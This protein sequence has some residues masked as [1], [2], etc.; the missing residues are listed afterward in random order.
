MNSL[1][2]PYQYTSSTSDALAGNVRRNIDAHNDEY[3]DEYMEE[4][5]SQCKQ[6]VNAVTNAGSTN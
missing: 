1:N 5:I 4:P 6:S 2:V 3:N